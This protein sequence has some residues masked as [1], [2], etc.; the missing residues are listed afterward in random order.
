MAIL[1]VLDMSESTITLRYHYINTKNLNF[2]WNSNIKINCAWNSSLNQQYNYN[3]FKLA[4]LIT[5]TV[6]KK[7][8]IIIIR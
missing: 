5:S 6:G 4:L 7:T 3:T 8:A 2:K 1:N